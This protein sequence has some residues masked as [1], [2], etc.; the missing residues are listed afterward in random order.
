MSEIRTLG[1][2]IVAKQHDFPHA[3]G[4]LSSLIGSIKLAAKIVNREINKAGLVDI[5]GA[6]GE[7]N[8]QGEQQQ[9]LDVY[10]NDKFKAALEARDQVCGVASEEEDEA[11]AFNKELNKNAKYVV[12]MDPLDGSSNIDVNVSVGTIFSIYRRISPIGTPATEEDFLQPGHKQVAAGYIIYGSSTMLVYTTGN[13]VHGFT[14]DPSLGVFC[15]SHEN[16]QIPKDGNIYSINEGNYI[17]FPEGIKQYLKFCQ[18]SKPEDNRPYT[19]RYI[20]SLVA[21]FHRNLLK[22]GI[23]LYPSTQAYPNGKLRLLYECNPMAMLIEEAGGK[24]TD[25]EQRILDIK[26][27]ELHQR[28]PFFVGSTNMVDKVHA[29][30]D[31]WRD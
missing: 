26:P 8:I 15:L 22:G 30:L 6:S 23:Y 17:R 18:E 3:S 13:G 12:L 2:F 27:S 24:A 5:T 1:E 20:G 16:M 21:D 28:V 29:F 25:G 10:A 31:E 4:E 11:V 7:E 19:S 9:K 14:Y